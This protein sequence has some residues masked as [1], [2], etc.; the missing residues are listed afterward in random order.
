M[1]FSTNI[2]LSYLI[3]QV[4]SNSNP[5]SETDEEPSEEEPSNELL[6]FLAVLNLTD[7]Y[8]VFKQ[9]K[10]D[11]EAVMMATDADLKALGLSMGPRLKIL[12]AMDARKSKM[13]SE[14]APHDTAF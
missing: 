14:K 4:P 2:A 1:C 9:E 10:M 12:R 7:Y 5:S 3:T 8:P 6:T 11:L 13:E